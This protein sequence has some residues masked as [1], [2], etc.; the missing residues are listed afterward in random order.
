MKLF[1]QMLTIYMELMED[2]INIPIGISTER[3]GVVINS[4]QTV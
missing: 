2:V 1:F 3:R 4:P